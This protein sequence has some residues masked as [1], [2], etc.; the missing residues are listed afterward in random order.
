MPKVAMKPIAAEIENG[1]P[2]RVSARMPPVAATGTLRKIR[3]ARRRSAEHHHEQHE[4]R[5]QGRRHDQV[6]RAVASW[7]FWNWPLQTSA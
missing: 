1:M 2:R 7:R 3:P 5:R 4:D 6:S